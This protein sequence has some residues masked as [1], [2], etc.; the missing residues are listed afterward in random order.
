MFTPIPISRFRVTTGITSFAPT[1]TEQVV[2]LRQIGKID[3]LEIMPFSGQSELRAATSRIGTKI[4][5]SPKWTPRL[6]CLDRNSSS[7]TNITR[8]LKD[9]ALFSKVSASRE[10]SFQDR[11]LLFLGG[12]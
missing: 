12:I 11:L 1:E 5:Q 10:H 9:S 3:R 6:Y 7:A 8:S 4:S 2:A